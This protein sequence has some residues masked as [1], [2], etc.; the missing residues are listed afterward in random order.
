M[1]GP[2]PPL[3]NATARN[4]RAGISRSVMWPVADPSADRTALPNWS[5]VQRSLEHLQLFKTLCSGKY[6]FAPR[7]W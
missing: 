6:G 1:E 5:C 7:A 3:N 2:A 4:S